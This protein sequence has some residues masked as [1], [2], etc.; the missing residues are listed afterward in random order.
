MIFCENRFYLRKVSKND[1]L[2]TYN[3]RSR[4][5]NVTYK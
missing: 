3:Y 5:M 4:I 2:Y 1:T